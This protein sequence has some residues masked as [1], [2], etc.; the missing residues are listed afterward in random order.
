[1]GVIEGREVN[2]EC[3]L[4]ARHSIFYLNFFT[5][6]TIG[7]Q[8][9]NATPV[10]TR[11]V[12]F[13]LCELQNPS[14]RKSLGEGEDLVVCF[15]R[16]FLTS[17]LPLTYYHLSHP[18]L[19]KLTGLPGYYLPMGKSLSGPPFHLS[20]GSVAHLNL[21]HNHNKRVKSHVSDKWFSPCFVIFLPLFTFFSFNTKFTVTVQ[22]DFRTLGEGL[23]L[24]VYSAARVCS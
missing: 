21:S 22:L 7:V 23:R 14:F 17:C 16:A 1:M 10:V 11:L 19:V 4:G 24:E 15:S 8:R 3:L 6:K 20:K 2:I 9:S 18:F 5:D 13:L 12:R